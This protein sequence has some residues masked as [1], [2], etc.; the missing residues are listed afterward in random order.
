[1]AFWKYTSTLKNL[2]Q[3]THLS[4]FLQNGRVYLAEIL[5]EVPSQQSAKDMGPTRAP[6][7][8]LYGSY[9]GT[10]YGT[11]MGFATQFHVVPTWANPY[12]S[13]YGNHMGPILDLA[14]EAHVQPTFVE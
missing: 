2:C 12:G 1:M 8:I 7:G 6:Y 9:M 4:L 3:P 11:G 5:Y 10:P 14:K 13:Q